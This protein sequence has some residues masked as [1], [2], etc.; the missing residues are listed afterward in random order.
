VAKFRIKIIAKQ[1][2]YGKNKRRYDVAN[3]RNNNMGEEFNLQLRNSFKFLPEET[4]D[5]VTKQWNKVIKDDYLKTCRK[6]D[7]IQE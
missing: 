2:T 4:T 1:N 7:R 6:F 5:Y 3:L